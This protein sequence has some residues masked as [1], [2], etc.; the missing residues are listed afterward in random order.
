MNL[1]TWQA[2]KH[3]NVNLYSILDT[4]NDAAPSQTWSHK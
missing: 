1:H 3:W 2:G 4:W